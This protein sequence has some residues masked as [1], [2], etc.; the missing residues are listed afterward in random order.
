MVLLSLPLPGD[1]IL[2]QMKA[3]IYGTSVPQNRVLHLCSQWIIEVI[4]LL[5]IILPFQRDVLVDFLV[6]L[7]KDG[8]F[9]KHSLEF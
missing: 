2:T 8:F 4:L 1:Y 5:H 6:W 7:R 9:S 3:V